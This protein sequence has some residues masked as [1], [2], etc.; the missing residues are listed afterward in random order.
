MDQENDKVP[1]WWDTFSDRQK[2]HILEGLDDAKNGRVMSS[3][4][5]WRRLKGEK[6]N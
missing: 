4:D 1:D 3:E 6:T 5:F 2:A